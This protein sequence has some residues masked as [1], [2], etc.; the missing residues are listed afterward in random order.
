VLPRFLKIESKYKRMRMV[1]S[2]R[3]AL[4]FSVAVAFLLIPG[5]S[6]GDLDR[7]VL[8]LA[9]PGDRLFPNLAQANK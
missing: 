4:T 8:L 5:C 6:G 2:I 9:H 1:L 3:M 7:E